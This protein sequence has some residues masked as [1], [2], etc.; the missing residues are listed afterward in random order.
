LDAS[1]IH[2]RFAG[3]VGADAVN[4]CECCPGTGQSGPKADVG[5]TGYYRQSVLHICN[6]WLSI[7]FNFFQ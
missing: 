3:T 7:F 2:T 4:I 1:F 6:T 5:I